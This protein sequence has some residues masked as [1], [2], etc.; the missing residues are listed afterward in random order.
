MPQPKVFRDVV[1]GILCGSTDT[2]D[3]RGTARNLSQM[4]GRTIVSGLRSAVSQA[5]DD[6]N[7]FARIHIHLEC[8]P[9]EISP[10]HPEALAWACLGSFAQLQASLVAVRGLVKCD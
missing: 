8:P 9:H 2:T 3:S 7:H 6:A 1:L 4:A 10:F 5:E